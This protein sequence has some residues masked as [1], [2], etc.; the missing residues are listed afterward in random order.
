M[1][2]PI[3]PETT[4]DVW[5]DA[6]EGVP[7]ESRPIFVCRHFTVRQYVLYEEL[8]R[9][10]RQESGVQ[11]QDVAKVYDLLVQ[12]LKL[13]I[14]GTRNYG[15]GTVEQI[16]QDG[17]APEHAWQLIDR[18]NKATDLTPK[19]NLASASLPE[20][21]PES[22]VEVAP[23]PVSA[24]RDSMPNLSFSTALPAAVETTTAHS[25]TELVK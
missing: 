19:K 17:I 11:N 5:L 1:N 15:D 20:S 9:Q 25:A 16:L 8:R 2:I 4:V 10:L 3:T 18:I 14:V 6:N 13:R 7:L 22:S 23:A 12:L 24:S 21:T